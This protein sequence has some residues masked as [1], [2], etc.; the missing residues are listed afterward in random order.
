MIERA[1]MS[2]L[3]QWSSSSVTVHPG[4]DGTVA[5]GPAAAAASASRTEFCASWSRYCCV[6]ITLSIR[7]DYDGL[8]QR[9]G[10]DALDQVGVVVVGRVDARAHRVHLEPVVGCGP[11][12]GLQRAEV[13]GV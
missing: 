1:Q 6:S 10:F 2:P 8:Q 11:Q 5:S 9:V 4:H 13:A 3:T 12:H 7:G